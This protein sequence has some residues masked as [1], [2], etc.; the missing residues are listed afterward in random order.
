MRQRNAT[1]LRAIVLVVV[2]FICSQL[3]A[4]WIAKPAISD[5]SP[6]VLVESAAPTND[7]DRPGDDAEQI[8][9]SLEVL[10]GDIA[11]LSRRMSAVEEGQ[12]R[13]SS[14]DA[15]ADLQRQVSQLSRSVQDLQDRVRRLEIYRR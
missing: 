13:A 7:S 8:R 14:P 2:L 6:R 9:R 10:Q 12:R 15:V 3:L 1:V 11:I 5:Q 4:T